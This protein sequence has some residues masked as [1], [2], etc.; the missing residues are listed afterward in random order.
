M[1]RSRISQQHEYLTLA[2]LA[3]ECGT[4]VHA[5][6]N[7]KAEGLIRSCAHTPGGYGLYDQVALQRLRLIRLLREACVAVCDIK[8][9]LNALDGDA[10]SFGSELRRLR[11]QIAVRRKTLLAVET[12]LD[13]LI[14][15][16]PECARELADGDSYARA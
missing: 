4:S 14:P 12:Q 11:Q 15:G 2:E 8:R 5:A 3:V 13:T 6:R 1:S 7:Y 16:A 9:L 10:E